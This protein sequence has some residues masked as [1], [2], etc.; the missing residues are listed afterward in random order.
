MLDSLEDARHLRGSAFYCEVERIKH[1][2]GGSFGRLRAKDFRRQRRQIEWDPEL[3]GS[4][5]WYED[6]SK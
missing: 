5:L 3:L 6:L 1:Q 4:P 2:L